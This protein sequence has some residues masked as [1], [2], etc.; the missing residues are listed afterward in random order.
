M[1]PRNSAIAALFLLTTC[2]EAG[3]DRSSATVESS[4]QAL[5][6]TPPSEVAT[7]AK[8]RRQHLA[9]WPLLAGRGL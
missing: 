2:N 4:S 6:K 9:G 1:K 3:Q 8:G 7:W 5:G